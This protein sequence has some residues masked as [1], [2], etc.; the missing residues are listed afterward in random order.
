MSTLPLAII[1][2]K[3]GNLT[4]VRLAFEM[5]GA[6]PCVTAD[7]ERV[8]AAQRIV[9]PGVGA[10]ASAMR[11]LRD[12]GLI[13]PIRAAIDRGVPFLGICLGMQILCAHSAEDDG[14]DTLGIIPGRVIAFDPPDP[15]DKVPH[16]GWNQVSLPTPP[17]PLFADIPNLSDFY[18]VHRYYPVPARKQDRLAETDYAGV[19]FAAAIGFANVFA[20]QFHPEKSGPVGLTM[21]RN[22]L[23][24]Q[25]DAPC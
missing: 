7:P 25:G 4:S 16:M 5:L 8:A 22:F 11:H 21:L 10:A 2:Y 17:H 23:N 1:D 9:F 12:G 13:A 6:T 19:R 18:F 15:R 24:W 3:A 14:V 20:T